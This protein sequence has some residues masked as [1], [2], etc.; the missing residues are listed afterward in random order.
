MTT[1]PIDGLRI[2]DVVTFLAVHRHGSLTSAAHDLRVTPSQ[3]SKAVA[4]LERRLKRS[5]LVRAGRGVALDETAADLVPLLEDLVERAHLLEGGLPHPEPALRLAAAS[6][7]CAAFMPAMV[8]ALPARRFRGVEVAPAFIRAFAQQRVFDLALTVGEQQLGIG[9]VSTRVGSV[10]Q[11]LFGSPRVARRLGK[12]V[13]V[14]RVREL[15]F[16]CS[17]HDKGG[18]WLPGDD[19]CPLPR[20]QRIVGHEAATFGVAIELAAACDQLVFGPTVAARAAV[21]VGK[22]VEIDV[23]ELHVT[24]T[25]D[26]HADGVRVLART[27]RAIMS[28][29]RAST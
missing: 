24:D 1:R 22:L 6:Y 2:A 21:E 26:F 18:R 29:L 10:P 12:K 25:L 27:Q 28:V 7:L 14:A 23:P 4:R 16:V 11:A 15:A 9:W 17:L 19:R 20:S 5:L 8:K 3:V 13:S